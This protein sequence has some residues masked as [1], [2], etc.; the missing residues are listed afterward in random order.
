MNSMSAG[1]A[2][3]DQVRDLLDKNVSPEIAAQLMRD[4]S[5]LG[6]EE[7]EVTILFADLRG[8]TTLS[9]HRTPHEVVALLN[10]Y[11]TRMSG[12]I[13]LSGG[14]IDKFIGDEIMALF[15]APVS[16]GNDANEALAAAIGMQAELKRL[17]AELALE[18]HP[19]LAFGVGIN[20]ARVIAGNIGSERRLNYSVLGDGVNIAARLQ[21]LT[22]TPEYRTNIIVSAATVEAAR[23]RMGTG[24]NF[25]PL[26]TVSVK[27]RAE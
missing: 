24:I 4:G 8:F 10:R 18:G 21:S 13:E 12:A 11:L 17:N 26:G 16:M 14:V 7:R 23:G 25:R 27:G 1:L 5:A 15:G 6:G 20:T 22:R 9:E 3:R 19:P 2:E